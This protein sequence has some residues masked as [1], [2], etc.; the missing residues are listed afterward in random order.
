MADAAEEGLAPQIEQVSPAELHF[1]LH[2][3][4]MAE[5][6]F[7]D[8]TTVVA[9]LVE[10]YD[11]EEI[12][13]SIL[14]AGW[15]DYE[16]LIAQRDGTVLE[17]N[18]RL[19]ALRLIEDAELRQQV[20][21]KL[22]AIDPAHL[23]A[24]PAHV[25]VRYADSREAA[26]VYIGFKHINGPFKWDALAKAKFAAD[27]VAAGHD[28]QL[29]SRTLGDSHNT[30]LRLVNGWNVLQRAKAEGFDPADATTGSPFPI[31][32]LYTALTRPDVR[33]YLGLEAPAR[34]VLNESDI[35]P[36]KTGNLLQLMNWLYGERSKGLPSVIRTQNP[37]L[38]TLV[39]VIAH[40]AA[41]DELIANRDLSAAAELL[42]PSHERFE[43]V[44]RQAARACEEALA[45]AKDYDG[46]PTLLDIVNNMGH[47][48]LTLRQAMLSRKSD[49][50][51][52]FADVPPKT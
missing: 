5:T 3:F 45:G 29:V 15:L 6:E 7:H 36:E 39:R 38:G 18:R 10:E 33:T 52:A 11:V 13:L 46:T 23:N 42:M 28:I 9:H 14:T 12:V 19:A 48:I 24:H 4:R 40:D 20:G 44:L 51:A 32:H 41:R 35:Q 43:I 31:S 47:T 8:E 17:G 16:P 26:Y 50:L 27:W 49:P 1:D 30:V 37:D 22:P 25:S 21:F 2:N 34:A